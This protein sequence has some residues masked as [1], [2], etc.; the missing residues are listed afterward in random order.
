MP[1]GGLLVWERGRIIEERRWWS[2]EYHLGEDRDEDLDELLRDSVRL[3]LRADV[4]VGTYLSGGL[5]S[6]LITALAQARPTIELR[7]FSIAFKDPRYDERAHQL[8]VAR[9]IGTR[10][11]VVEAGPGEIADAFPEVI[12][13]VEMPLVRT[14]PVPLFLLAREVRAHQI[15]VVATGEGADELFWGYE[16]FKEVVLRELS[17]REPERAEEL[18]EQLYAYL[19]PAVARR[20]PAWRRF[21]LETGRDDE[22]LGSHLTRATATATVKAFYRP[23]I[24]AEEREEHIARPPS[25]RAAAVLWALEPAGARGVARVGDLARA[26]PALSAGGSRCD[27]PRRRGTFPLSR[28]PSLRPLRALARRE[29]TAGNA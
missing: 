4:P 22:E 25:G 14:A 26:L 28:P 23:E 24:A 17:T 21:L 10:H 6:S 27:G 19:G 29:K 16:L 13:H 3:R 15:T 20:G 11:H 18:L 8:E 2:P 5:D 9:A 7:T 1:P 12:R